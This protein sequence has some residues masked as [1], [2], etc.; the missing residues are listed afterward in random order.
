M[1][2]YL[3]PIADAYGVADLALVRGGTMGM[4]EL[5][6]WGIPMI[7]VPLPTAAADHQS[8]NARA[9]EAEGAGIHLPQRDLTPQRLAETVANVT[10]DERRLAALADGA[11]R[12][13]RPDAARDIAQRIA[14]LLP[15]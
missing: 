11:R 12:R 8:W 9:L 1:V 2:D 4:A 3:A 6:A 14:A 15:T 7:V 10:G 5:C 13:G